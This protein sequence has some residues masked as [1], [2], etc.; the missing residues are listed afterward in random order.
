MRYGIGDRFELRLGWNYEVGREHM[1]GGGNIAGFFS[2]PKR[3]NNSST[4]A[5][6]RS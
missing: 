3:P 5:S 1:P 2:G 4:T 6:R